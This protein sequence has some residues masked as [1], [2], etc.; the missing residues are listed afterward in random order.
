MLSGL[1]VLVVED[2]PMI[3]AD[4]AGTVEE[5]GAVVIGPCST[6]TEARQFAR[7]PQID[8]AILDVSLGD[9]D[10]TLVLEALLARRI[11]VL[12]YTGAELPPKLQ[13]RHPDPVVLQK[14]LLPGRLL[15]ELNRVHRHESAQ[16]RGKHCNAL[17]F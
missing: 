17:D 15:L 7:T 2:E 9:G 4:L 10:I 5:G 16:T 14:P 1:Y 13:D 6:I 3:A 8:A 11:L 12:V